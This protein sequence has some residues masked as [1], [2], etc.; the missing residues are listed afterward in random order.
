MQE[1]SLLLPVL[2][3]VLESVKSSEN[4]LKSIDKENLQSPKNLEI[5]DAVYL[6]LLAMS[7]VLNRLKSMLPVNID[8]NIEENSLDKSDIYQLCSRQ[9]PVLKDKIKK[10]IESV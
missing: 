7:E 3:Q 5:L 8:F 4:A 10:A 1:K 6:Q 9:L 2:K